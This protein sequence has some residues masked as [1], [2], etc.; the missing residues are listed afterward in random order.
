MDGFNNFI[1][2]I[3]NKSPVEEGAKDFR[4]SEGVLHCGICKTPKECVLEFPLHSGKYK[5]FSCSCKCVEDE[6]KRWLD[7]KRKQ[8]YE[9]YI[10]RLKQQGI[11]DPAHLKQVFEKDDGRNPQVHTRC[12]NYVKN[13]EEVNRENIGILFY[14]DTGR[15]KSFF[16]CCIA[17]ALIQKGVPV[18]VTNLSK[19]V[20]D[21]LSGDSHI[22]IIT[23][24]LLVLDDLGV[25]NATATAYNIID[26]RYRSGKPIVITTNLTL[27]ELHSPD[28]LDKQRIYDR[29][30]E[31]CPARILVKSEITREVMAKRKASKVKKLLSGD[32]ISRT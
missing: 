12:E 28:T 2:G 3:A 21:R 7:E 27:Q 9:D 8:E 22:N 18:L 1:E 26:E 11:T 4:D 13:W 15:G 31:L 23:P 14:G 30:L 24:D 20:K 10:K 6:E 5:C 32:S 25:E 19:L 16:A 29:V 17:N